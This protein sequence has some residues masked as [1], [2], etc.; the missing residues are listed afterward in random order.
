MPYPL[1]IFLIIAGLAGFF[2]LLRYLAYLMF[3]WHVS[4]MHGVAGLRAMQYVATPTYPRSSGREQL[5]S[6]KG[7]NSEQTKE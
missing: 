2:G 4:K 3:A 7:S 6:G 1:S 5:E